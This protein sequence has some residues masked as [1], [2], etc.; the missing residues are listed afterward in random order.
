VLGVSLVL[1]NDLY[2]DRLAAAE[3]YPATGQ[4]RSFSGNKIGILLAHWVWTNFRRLHP[5]VAPAR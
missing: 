1:A 5:E 4:W 2:A 3:K